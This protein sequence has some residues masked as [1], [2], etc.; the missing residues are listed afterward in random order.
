MEKMFPVICTTR[1]AMLKY[2]ECSDM[3]NI[4]LAGVLIL[5]TRFHCQDEFGMHTAKYLGNKVCIEL[6]KVGLN[7]SSEVVSSEKNV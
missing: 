4:D 6:N 3:E 7:A 2:L 5:N 1:A